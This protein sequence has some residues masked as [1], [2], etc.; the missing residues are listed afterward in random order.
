MLSNV[1]KQ[2]HRVSQLKNINPNILNV[3]EKPV[4]KIEVNF[5]VKINN[6]IKIFSGYRIQHNNYFGPFKGGIRY[7]ENVSSDEVN[8]LSQLMTY[9]CIIQNI[10][11][12]GAKVGLKIDINK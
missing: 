8:A 10:P 12:G 11:F 4:N 2:I 1:K 6:S 3:V 9:K 5:P 7:H